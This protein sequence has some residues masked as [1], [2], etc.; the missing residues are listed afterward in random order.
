MSAD[1]PLFHRLAPRE[2]LLWNVSQPPSKMAAI[3]SIENNIAHMAEAASVEKREP[4]SPGRQRIALLS[5][6]FLVIVA[7]AFAAEY[8]RTR[9]YERREAEACIERYNGFIREAK[10]NLVRGDRT[11]AIN[12]LEAARVQLHHCEVQSARSVSGIWR[13]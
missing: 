4:M 11:A 1:R 13:R 5:V 3:T 12:S 9:L 2:T 10:A 8:V 6:V 7:A